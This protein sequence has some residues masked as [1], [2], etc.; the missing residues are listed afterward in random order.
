MFSSVLTGNSMTF[1]C[2]ETQSD[3]TL[4]NLVEGVKRWNTRALTPDERAE[5]KSG[6]DRCEGSLS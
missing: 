1:D 4:R 3:S 6:K 5:K 2:P